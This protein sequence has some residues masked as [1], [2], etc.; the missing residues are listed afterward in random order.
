V[1][2]AADEVQALTERLDEIADPAAREAADELAAALVALYGDALERILELGGDELRERLAADDDLGGLLL[3]HGLHPVDLETRVR[4]ALDEVR[5]YLESH[6]GDIELLGIE[7]GV[8]RLRLQGSC[9]GCAASAATLEGAVEQVL[10]D[11]APDL[12]GMDVEGAVQR[13]KRPPASSSE[14]V[15]LDGAQ[16]IPR[17]ALAKVTSALVIANVAG[18][19]LAYRNACANCASALDDALLLGGTLT[20]AACGAGYD[21]PRA[22]RS[23]NRDGLQLDPVPLLRHKGQVKVALS[24]ALA[25]PR[26]EHAEASTCQLCPTGIGDDHRHLLHLYE[27][28]IVCVCETCW[29]MRSGDSEYR[30]CG[31]RTLWLDDFELPDEVWAQLQIPIGLAFVM[32][33]SMTGTVAALYPSPAGATESEIDLFAWNAMVDANPMLDRLEADAEAL[34]VNRLSDPPQYAIAPIDQCYRLVGLIKSRWEGIS[35]GTA[36]ESAVAEFFD[37]LHDRALVGAP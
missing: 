30:P 13:P 10:R 8:A 20:C 27:R 12:A 29:S 5:P 6:G 32:R 11:A 3:A 4:R 34:I 23:T 35:G 9:D 28:R 18:T 21:L 2:T 26:A 15:A 19:L 1:T 16:D 36:I 25:P 14:W 22:G 33:S 7:D 31:V 37:E 24:G 17:G